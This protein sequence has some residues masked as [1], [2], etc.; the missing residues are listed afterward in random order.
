MVMAEPDGLTLRRAYDSRLAN[1]AVAPEV[2]L[3]D[4]WKR[5]LVTH[6]LVELVS[7]Q[8]RDVLSARLWHWTQITLTHIDRP[9]RSADD[10]ACERLDM[11]NSLR[12]ECIVANGICWIWLVQ[13]GICG[14]GETDVSVFD[15]GA[16]RHWRAWANMSYVSL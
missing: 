10:L 8:I 9:V 11:L 16:P 5:T 7:F 12:L 13:R 2:K 14:D 6:H 1:P 3:V 4:S 15:G